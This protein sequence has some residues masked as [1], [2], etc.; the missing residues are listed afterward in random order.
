MPEMGKVKLRMLTPVGGVSVSTRFSVPLP[1]PPQFTVQ[2]FFTPLQEERAK[3]A[4]NAS[5]T[6]HRLEFMQIPRD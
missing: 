4:A 1:P 6:A 3:I 2:G 5:K